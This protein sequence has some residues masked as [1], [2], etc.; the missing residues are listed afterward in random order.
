M[1]SQIQLINTVAWNL[2]I[3]LGHRGQLRF[4]RAVLIGVV[5]LRDQVRERRSRSA[6]GKQKH[7]RGGHFCGSRSGKGLVPGRFSFS[8]TNAIAPGGIGGV[9]GEIHRRNVLAFGHVMHFAP[10]G[11]K[12]ALVNPIALRPDLAGRQGIV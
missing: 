3:R 11:A 6:L 2:S 1:I 10:I 4:G 5:Q 12:E 9:K 7:F 8:G